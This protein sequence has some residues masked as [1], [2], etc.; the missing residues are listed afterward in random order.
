ML[1]EETQVYITFDISSFPI[2]N[3]QNNLFLKLQLQVFLYNCTSGGKNVLSW[4]FGRIFLNCKWIP[5]VSS[6]S[7][8]T[9]IL[10]KGWEPIHTY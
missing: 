2:K 10:V 9:G 3:H 4:E 1:I 6:E 8:N 7:W 5:P